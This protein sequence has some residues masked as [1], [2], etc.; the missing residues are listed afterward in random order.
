[1]A[2]QRPRGKEKNAIKLKMDWFLSF[3]PVSSAHSASI[4]CCEAFMRLA[5]NLFLL[6]NLEQLWSEIIAG[7]IKRKH[8]RQFVIKRL[9]RFRNGRKI[10]NL[11]PRCNYDSSLSRFSRFL[12]YQQEEWVLIAKP[13]GLISDPAAQACSLSAHATLF[14][15][16]VVACF[17][18]A[19]ELL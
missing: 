16:R 11:G 1:M 10:D 8:V 18:P 19:H 7:A 3:L 5:F 17:D 14:G 12:E 4:M 6:S 9:R 2:G 13:S 15:R